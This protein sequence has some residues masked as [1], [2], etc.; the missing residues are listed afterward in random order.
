MLPHVAACCRMD[1]KLCEVP[2]AT[3]TATATATTM[4]KSKRVRVLHTLM[5]RQKAKQKQTVAH[6][7]QLPP[8]HCTP[9]PS[10]TLLLCTSLC[11]SVLSQFSIVP[12]PKR[13]QQAMQS[14]ARQLNSG[15]QSLFDTPCPCPLWGMM[16]TMTLLTEGCHSSCELWQCK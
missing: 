16:M 9:S 2:P 5:S 8:A 12:G 15:T 1:R 6:G 7:I 10:L 3:T 4:K 11:P 14:V 13:Q